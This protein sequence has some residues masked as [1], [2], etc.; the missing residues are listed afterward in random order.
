MKDKMEYVINDPQIGQTT[1]PATGGFPAANLPSPEER[2]AR[3][4]HDA[5]LKYAM[6]LKARRDRENARALKGRVAKRRRQN[7]VAKASRKRN[8]V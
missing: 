1:I 4:A 5:A 8:R 7:V 3:I 2:I 6:V